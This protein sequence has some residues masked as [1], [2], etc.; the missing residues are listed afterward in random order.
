MDESTS[1]GPLTDPNAPQV[2]SDRVAAACADGAKLI[3][4]GTA[5][6]DAAGKGNFMSP[7]LVTNVD[8][9]HELFSKESFG[10]I[11]AISKVKSPEEAVTRMN[12]NDYGLT[13]AVYTQDREL[14]LNIAEKL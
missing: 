5:T 10:P 2:L 4:G 14:A 7:T 3:S 1:M 6:T 9:E 8:E 13:N 12:T 11:V